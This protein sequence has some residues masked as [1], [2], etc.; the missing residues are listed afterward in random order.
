MLSARR[1]EGRRHVLV[2]M[3]RD[4]DKVR[5]NTGRCRLVGIE[6]TDWEHYQQKKW[7]QY[8]SWVPL[9]GHTE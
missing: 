2:S 7:M 6:K 8:G 4:R 1:E 5:M 3:V 9:G